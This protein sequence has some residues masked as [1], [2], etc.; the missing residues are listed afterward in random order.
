MQS[1]KDE[2]TKNQILNL[3]DESTKLSSSQISNANT[4]NT[5]SHSLKI[6]ALLSSGPMNLEAKKLTT[7][8]PATA[9]AS[10]PTSSTLDIRETT[11]AKIVNIPITSNPSVPLIKVSESSTNSNRF[12]QDRFKSEMVRKNWKNVLE[13]ALKNKNLIENESA[14]LNSST[15]ANQ[16]FSGNREIYAT[17]KENWIF[18]SIIISIVII[19]SVL[20]CFIVYW[21][22]PQFRTKSFL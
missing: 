12:N 7:T 2:Q 9:A 3:P 10:L 11:P 6:Q 20:F 18:F 14:A 5:L 1:E 4:P 19:L 15:N 21:F 8:L 16:S 22:F 13:V 17:N